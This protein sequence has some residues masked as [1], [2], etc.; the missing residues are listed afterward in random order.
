MR[1]L[2]RRARRTGCRMQGAAYL[3]QRVPHRMSN[4]I[5][6]G[7]H[8]I[9]MAFCR[10]RLCVNGSHIMKFGFTLAKLHILFIQSLEN[11]CVWL[12][13]EDIHA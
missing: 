12:K 13:V 10:L 5:S 7:P 3:L 9:E 2:H 6:H 8:Q 11:V 1:R 4:L